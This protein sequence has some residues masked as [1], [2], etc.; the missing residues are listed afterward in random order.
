MARFKINGTE[1][2]FDMNSM[3]PLSEEELETASGGFQPLESMHFY[4]W[5]CNTCHEEGATFLACDSAFKESM[6]AHKSATGHGVFTAI[7]AIGTICN[8]RIGYGVNGIWTET[9]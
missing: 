7:S 3:K 8:D 6:K 4:S 5:V 1:I 2:E 9:V